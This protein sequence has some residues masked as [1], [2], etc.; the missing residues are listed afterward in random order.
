MEK[1]LMAE[2]FLCSPSPSIPGNSFLSL[3]ELGFELPP[4]FPDVDAPF[5]GIL[6]PME[7]LELSGSHETS[8]GSL[9]SVFWGTII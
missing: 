5:P 2:G 4:L 3:P 7:D 1:K 6:L 9:P 8:L